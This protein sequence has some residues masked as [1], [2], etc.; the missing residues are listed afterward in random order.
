MSEQS[1]VKGGPVVV[2]VVGATGHTARF[3]IHELLRRGATPIAVA[4][5]AEALAK[6]DFSGRVIPRGAATGSPRSID[7]ALEGAQAV[8]NCAGPFVDSV[9]DIAKAAVRLGIHYVDITAEE[10]SARWTFETL[11]APA[12]KAGVALVPSVGFYGALGDLLASAAVGEWKSAETV[13]VIIGLDGWHPTVG[14]RKTIARLTDLK[15]VPTPG[16][17]S[18]RPRKKQ[19][20][21]A[22]P[23]GAQSL[24][25]FWFTEKLLIQRH[26]RTDELRVYLSDVAL[27]DVS[28]PRTP[29]PKAVDAMG[30]SAQRFCVEV[31]ATNRAQWRRASASGVDAYAFTA[32]LACEVAVRLIGG[33]FREPGARTPGE[34]F[35]SVDVLESLRPEFLDFRMDAA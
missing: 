4:R 25:E 16:G 31:V 18:E 3:V 7:S 30:R 6:A 29:I 14:T 5:D 15:A 12:R 24:S 20:K 11:D 13:D 21:F 34:L 26:I 28:D 32:P 2:A 8:I 1:S 17:D 23:L 35:D 27:G 10:P 33:K 22:E 19:W 9:Q